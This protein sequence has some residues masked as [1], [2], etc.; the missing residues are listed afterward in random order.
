MKIELQ[1][2]C[3]TAGTLSQGP[4]LSQTNVQL[5]APVSHNEGVFSKPNAAGGLSMSDVTPEFAA[6]F[7]PGKQ[8]KI[9]VEEVT[10]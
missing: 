1:T 6:Q 9:T 5:L 2:Y 8:Y 3:H 4:G 7:Q 10:S